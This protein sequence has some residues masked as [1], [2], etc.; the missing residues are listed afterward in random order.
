MTAEAP[1]KRRPNGTVVPLT[2]DRQALAAAHVGLAG[3]WLRE[4]PWAARWFGEDAYGMALAAIARAAG[5]FRPE[6]GFAFTTY[7]SQCIRYAMLREADHREHPKRKARVV[8]LHAEL[9]P[10]RVTLL[11]M[12]PDRPADERDLTASEAADRVA[13]LLRRVTPREREVLRLRYLD[14]LTLSEV[15]DRL[16]ISNE[17]VRQIEKIA[18]RRIKGE[19]TRRLDRRVN[20][21]PQRKDVPTMPRKKAV[22]TDPARP[23]DAA[24]VI[25]ARIAALEAEQR[26]VEARLAELRSISQA[27][28][29]SQTAT[30][31][32]V[33]TTAKPQSRLR[34]AAEARRDVRADAL[35]VQA[36]IA[37]HGP[38]HYYDLLKLAKLSGKLASQ[39]LS[40]QGWFAKDD[41]SGLWTLTE[42]GKE[43]K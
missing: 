30:A 26:L 23:T 43:A 29:D 10:D 16:G 18:I 8:S 17:R 28:G 35:V 21:N 37:Q 25:A 36:V 32:V 40:F 14:G 19:E 39:A 20:K 41:E 15:A 42:A 3:W 6:L 9:G 22:Q 7:A 31:T 12:V 24:S 38:T 1:A 13:D 4:N 2:A 34:P 11:D 33:G 27:M 5:E